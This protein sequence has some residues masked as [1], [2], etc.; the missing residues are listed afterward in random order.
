MLRWTAEEYQRYIHG[1]KSPQS[2]K[3]KF[4]SERVKV[5]GI[6]FDSK[7][8]AEYYLNLKLLVKAGAIQGFCRQPRF[9]VTYGDD[10]TKATEYVADFIVL[11]NDDTYKIVDT[12]GVKTKEF[13]LKMK[14]LHEK[15]PELEVEIV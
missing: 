6:L 15:Y 8:E 9:V 4:K 5:D 3:S 1:E 2:K 7:K 13:K 12:K 10:N 11:N 14:A